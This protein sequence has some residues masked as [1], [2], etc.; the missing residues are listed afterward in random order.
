MNK[1]T[2]VIFLFL[3]WLSLP[4]LGEEPSSE[5]KSVIQA[6]V[7]QNSD[8]AIARRIQDIFSEV[9]SLKNVEV[10]VQAG[11]VRLSGMTTDQQ[12]AQ[13]AEALVARVDGVVTIENAIR[14]DVSLDSQLTP[15]L[16]ESRALLD[17]SIAV[18]PLFTLSLLV[19]VFI[20]MLGNFIARRKHFWEKITPNTFIAELAATTVRF[21]FFVMGLVLAL[22]LLGA[23][24]LLG[25]V[26]GSAGVIGL[27]VGFA[28]RDTIENYIASIM[29]SLRQPFR[30]K[31]HVIIN[32]NEGRVIRLTSRATILMTLD[33]NHLRIP[34]SEVFKGTILNYSSNPERRFDFQLG[35]DAND[36]PLAAIQ[37]GVEVLRT[38]DFVL[39]D[40][41]PQGLIRQVGDSN[42]VILYTGWVDQRQSDFG[43]SRSFALAAVKN[44]LESSGFG[45]P[46]PIYR[47]RF[48][49]PP[50]ALGGLASA[51]IHTDTVQTTKKPA[52]GHL[53]LLAGKDMD[54]AP[55]SHLDQ[56]VEEE[57]R[58]SRQD[59]LL[60]PVAPSE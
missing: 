2:A 52:P 57:R 44:A 20:V 14:R 19:F 32:N 37:T 59:D 35:V 9:P 38:L 13:R 45:L 24:T 7:N 46:E 43:K 49:S 53:G 18:L 50:A 60:S 22:N 3:C 56:K 55:D 51:S 25:A 4:V 33:G 21:L 36:D 5:P 39:K 40:P 1:I 10:S 29:L 41:P 23:T 6:N 58:E 47:L 17:N 30:P 34:N 54:L 8:K 28:V 48:D 15:A 12:A 11:V 16:E 27:A 31:D 42:I 26:L